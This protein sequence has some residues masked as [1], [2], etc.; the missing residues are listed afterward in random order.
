[1]ADFT[2]IS[3][4]GL[5][6]FSVQTENSQVETTSDPDNIT[7]LGPIAYVYQTIPPFEVIP[8]QENTGGSKFNRGFN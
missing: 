7:D 1:M 6:T 4:T 8:L 3:T 5:F 2:S